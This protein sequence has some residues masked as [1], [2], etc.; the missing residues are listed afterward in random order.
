MTNDTPA[1]KTRAEIDRRMAVFV[2]QTAELKALT[3]ELAT[4]RGEGPTLED[5]RD[6][7]CTLNGLIEALDDLS[8]RLGPDGEPLSAIIVSARPLAARLAIGLD[9][10]TTLGEAKSHD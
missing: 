8:D 6:T 9:D 4:L 10:I 2:K 7:A 5:L 1:S 3:A